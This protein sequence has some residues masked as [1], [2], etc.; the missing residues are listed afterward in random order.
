M[1]WH[2]LYCS[3]RP[4]QGGAP[5]LGGGRGEGQLL[6]PRGRGPVLRVALWR[7]AAASCGALRPPVPVAAL[8]HLPL[9]LVL[10][11]R[12]HQ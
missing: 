3:R 4:Q 9:L 1:I 10:L 6:A 2:E 5:L 11:Q 7:A 12:L 8:K